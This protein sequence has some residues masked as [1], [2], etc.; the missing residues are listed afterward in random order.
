MTHPLCLLDAPDV[1]LARPDANP[2]AIGEP[3]VAHP[4]DRLRAMVRSAHSG[5]LDHAPA[6]PGLGEHSVGVVVGRRGHRRFV[7]HCRSTYGVHLYVGR[8]CV[9]RCRRGDPS[10]AYGDHPFCDRR[11][12]A[13]RSLAAWRC[14]ARYLSRCQV[15]TSGS[16]TSP[17]GCSTPSA[18]QGLPLQQLRPHLVTK[19][20]ESESLSTY[21]GSYG[22]WWAC[23]RSGGAPLPPRSANT[24]RA[25]ALPVFVSLEHIPS[26]GVM[27]FHRVGWDLCRAGK[28]DLPG[29]AQSWTIRRQMPV[30]RT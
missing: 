20:R 4:H 10:P 5:R 3:V 13:R 9:A 18:L 30:L 8:P 23:A 24:G 1:P 15:C 21:L 29:R 22:R 7:R 2:L 6:P 12:F 14:L 27:I 25:L 11:A 16:A 17:P 19:R 28:S 26:L